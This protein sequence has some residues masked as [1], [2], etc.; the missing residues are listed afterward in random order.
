MPL[1]SVPATFSAD[2]LRAKQQAAD[3]QCHVDVGF[4]GG[5]A[6]VTGTVISPKGTGAGASR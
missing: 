5:I 3:G 2:A 6:F 4:W 1:N